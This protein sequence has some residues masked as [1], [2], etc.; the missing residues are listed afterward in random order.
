MIEA[1]EFRREASCETLAP[2]RVTLLISSL[3][4]GGAERVMAML[5]NGW[6][7]AGHEVCLVTLAGDEREDFYPLAPDIVRERLGVQR[8]SGNFARAIVNNVERWRKIRKVLLA[9]SPD[10]VVAF[11]T[12]TNILAVAAAFG[13]AIPVI[14]AERV[15][16]EDHAVSR[17]RRL[18]RLMAYRRAAAV[19][20][21]TKRSAMWLA[22]AIPGAKP[23]VIGN[24][25]VVKRGEEPDGVARSVLAS[26]A[27]SEMLLAMGRLDRQ[28]G[29]DLL[30]EA[31]ASVGTAA[32]HWR[33][34]IAGEGSERDE[35]KSLAAKLGLSDR[36][37][38]PGV[39][40]TPHALMERAGL[41]VLSSRYEGMPNALLEAMACGAACVS[42]DC[43]TGPSEIISDGVDGILVRGEDVMALARALETAM[44]DPELR[45]LLGRN[46]RAG[47]R[48]HALPAILAEWDALFRSVLSDSGR[49]G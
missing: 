47:G 19:V 30:L 38:L 21:L 48:R 12:D 42:F 41:F 4:I 26:C 39:T 18:F 9:R 44:G 11:L 31:F 45:V 35:L 1:I 28:K 3:G 32:R 25:V 34:V 8:E 7:K 5:A 46:A 23:A 33:L 40:A 10:I 20:M 14:V 17:G 24:P 49:G 15:S 37:L 29:F 6:A 13:L 27:K 16:P 22:R 43:R 36:V 2:L